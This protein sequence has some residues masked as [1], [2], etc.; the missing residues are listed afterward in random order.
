LEFE[1]RIKM[2]HR[3]DKISDKIRGTPGKINI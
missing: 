2:T 1:S 3:D